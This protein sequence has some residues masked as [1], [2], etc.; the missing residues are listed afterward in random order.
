MVALP[1]GSSCTAVCCGDMTWAFRR[2]IAQ[3]NSAGAKLAKC[4]YSC[5]SLSLLC[6]TSVAVLDNCLDA[7]LDHCTNPPPVLPEMRLVQLQSTDLQ[8][9]HSL[10]LSSAPNLPAEMKHHIPECELVMA[11]S[12]K[13]DRQSLLCLPQT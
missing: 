3:S 11:P 13:G 2:G 10:N 12:L 8:I 7:W 6:N 4:E 1:S 9:L 5:L